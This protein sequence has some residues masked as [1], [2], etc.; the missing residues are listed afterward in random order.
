MVKAPSILAK[1][2][3]STVSSITIGGAQLIE[4]T[5]EKFRV[6]LPNWK[7]LQGYGNCT[8]SH[9]HM[10]RGLPEFAAI[11]QYLT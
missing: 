8:Y 11:D 10:H 4:E 1:Y 6:L 5:A 3:L 9:S 7:I 2:D